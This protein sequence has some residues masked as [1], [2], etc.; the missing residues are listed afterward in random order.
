VH[1]EEPTLPPGCGT[2][3]A[4][5][6]LL[7]SGCCPVL[8]AES[9]GEAPAVQRLCPLDAENCAGVGMGVHVGLGVGVG[10]G[11][12]VLAVCCLGIAVVSPSLSVPPSVS[13][14]GR[15]FLVATVSSAACVRAPSETSLKLQ[16]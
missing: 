10:V 6:F 16:W 5:A 12:V 2:A 11:V 14:C 7:L 13:L 3:A 8:C 15:Y 9:T 1:N 4:D